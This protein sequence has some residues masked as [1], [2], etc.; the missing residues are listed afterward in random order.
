M[1]RPQKPK[2]TRAFLPDLFY[3]FTDSCPF[4]VTSSYFLQCSKAFLPC[5]SSHLAHRKSFSI[6]QCVAN[7]SVIHTV[8]SNEPHQGCEFR[9]K[10]RN[11]QCSYSFEVTHFKSTVEILEGI[12]CIDSCLPPSV[13]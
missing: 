3:P 10:N 9:K 2:G 11:F 1:P 12:Y 4:Q 8:A 5:N 7:Y 13:I 6:Y